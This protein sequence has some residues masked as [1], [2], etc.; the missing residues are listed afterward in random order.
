MRLMYQ[1]LTL[2]VYFLVGINLSFE[3]LLLIDRHNPCRAYGNAS[4][5]DITNLVKTWPVL[6][7]GTGIDGKEYKYWWS[8]SGNIGECQ[9][10]DV[11]V[12]Q[13]RL[14]G[15]TIQFNAGNLSPQLWFGQFNGAIS[16]VNESFVYSFELFVLIS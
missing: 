13:Q 14:D 2:F 16:Q 5:Y 11:A 1:I 4:V 9:D 15:P 8:C 10:S 7:N 6:L 3:S 12:C